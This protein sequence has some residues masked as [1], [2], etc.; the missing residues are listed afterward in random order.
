MDS[1]RLKGTNI[2]KAINGTLITDR[3]IEKQVVT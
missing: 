3:L 2:R 1:G